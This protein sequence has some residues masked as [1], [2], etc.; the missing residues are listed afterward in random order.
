[1]KAKKHYSTIKYH[2]YIIE[3]CG[4]IYE[5]YYHGDYIGDFSSLKEAKK[6][7][8]DEIKEFDQL[9]NK[10]VIEEAI[11]EGHSFYM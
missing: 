1:M 3:G 10:A 11:E 6:Y 9:W 4:Y 5:M 2:G 8:D 7:I